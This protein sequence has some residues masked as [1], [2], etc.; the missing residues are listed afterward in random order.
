[1]N[2]T[3]EIQLDVE[4]LMA[5]K[6]IRYMGCL[7]YMTKGAYVFNRRPYKT[8]QEAKTAVD[9]GIQAIGRAI[10]R[11]NQKLRP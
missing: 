3:S 9:N 1:M 7:I 8:I 5:H 10:E 4:R 2:A 6:C 11:G